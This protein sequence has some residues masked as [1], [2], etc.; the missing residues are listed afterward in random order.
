MPTSWSLQDAK[1][2]FSELARRAEAEGPQFVTRHG[3]AAVVVVSIEEYRRLAA[4]KEDLVSF[5]SRSPLAGAELD[6][7]RDASPARELEL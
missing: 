2:K 1:N 6:L 4:P 5:L 3:R 7:E